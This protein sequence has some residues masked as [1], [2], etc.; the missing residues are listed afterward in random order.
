M[1]V[2]KENRRVR[3]LFRSR[4]IDDLRQVRRELLILGRPRL[5]IGSRATG[6]KNRCQLRHQSCSIHTFHTT[7]HNPR[8]VSNRAVSRSAD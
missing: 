3:V 1:A 5:N 6:L 7:G 2:P 4:L 8:R